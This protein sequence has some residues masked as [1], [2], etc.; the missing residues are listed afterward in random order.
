LSNSGIT[1]DG[2]FEHWVPFAI[3]VRPDVFL[4]LDWTEFDADDH[5]TIALYLITSHGRA[6]PLMWKTVQKSQIEGWRNAHEDDLLARFAGF[7]PRTLK[8]ATVLADRGFGDQKLYPFLTSLGLDFV[9]RFR[10]VIQVE[11]ATGEV[12][13]AREWVPANGRPRKIPDAKVTTHK[14]PVAAV[15]CVHARGMEDAW[16]MATSR[17]DLTGAQ[18]VKEYGKRFRIEETFR[19]AKDSR[20]GMGLKATHI[21]NPLRRDRLLILAAMAQALLTLLGAAA[22]ETGLDRMLKA[23]TSKKR[24]HSLFRQGTYWYGAIP[25]MPD[26]WLVPLM[27]AFG[28]LVAE[29]RTFSA[30]LGIL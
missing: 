12:R 24:T 17:G 1:L 18:V 13:T 20:F 25:T 15:V 23:N 27:E 26:E 3:G 16:Q 21:K 2:F 19:D 28:R 6:T 30:V 29:Q 4:A 14:T 5:S 11:A 9:V 8:R 7:K 10:G 22:E